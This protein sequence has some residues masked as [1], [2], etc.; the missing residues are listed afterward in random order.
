MSR[1]VT[2]QSLQ[3][4]FLINTLVWFLLE[5][6]QQPVLAGASLIFRTNL[7]DC[8][9]FSDWA[10]TDLRVI[11]FKSRVQST[12]TSVGFSFMHASPPQPCKLLA[13]QQSWPQTEKRTCGANCT[14]CWNGD[15]SKGNILFTRPVY[16]SEYCQTHNNSGLPVT[17]SG[18]FVDHSY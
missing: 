7:Y 14:N 13:R 12:P 11:M 8:W 1:A 6:W 9:R 16:N 2:E 17:R 15:K 10:Q 3:Q 18:T 4:C 5:I